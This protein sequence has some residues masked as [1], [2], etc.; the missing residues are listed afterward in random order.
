MILLQRTVFPAVNFDTT[1]DW[2][3]LLSQDLT[4]GYL[5]EPGMKRLQALLSAD[6]KSVV[7]ERHYIDKDYRNTFTHFH[8]KRFTTPPS[9]CLRLH[10]FS[11]HISEEQLKGE[12]DLL[13]ENT[14]YLGYSVIRATRPN[15]IGRT[16]ICDTV[17][18]DQSS[19]VC[20][21]AENVHLM[22]TKLK[23]SGFPFISQDADA[24]VCA[25][26]ALWMLLRYFSNRYPNYRET[27]PFQITQ[28]ASN[29]AVGRR[30]FPSGG[31]T[32]WQIAEALR[33]NQFAPLV[34]SPKLRKADETEEEYAKRR[35]QFEH[36]LYTYIESGFPLLVTVEGHVFTAYGHSSNFSTA[37]PHSAGQPFFS[38]SYNQSIIISDDNCY[39]YQTLNK[40]GPN[41][42][43]CSRFSFNEITSFIVPLPEKVFLTAESAQSAIMN[44]LDD[45]KTGIDAQSPTLAGEE[46]TYRL[47]LTTTRSF[48]SKLRDR[49]MGNKIV[50][51]YYRQLPLPHFI[52]VCEIAL[53]EEYRNEHKIQGEVIWDATR[54]A[55]E[56]QGWI[57]V[58]YP[59]I[60]SLDIGSAL[61]SK[62][63]VEAIKLQGSTSY[64][65]LTS[66]LKNQP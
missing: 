15:S 32:S 23:V 2:N 60:L 14:K 27:L 5:D 63:H 57:A 49:G 17:R 62:K 64:P 28:L 47:Y 65:L 16:L 12:S 21:C 9:R 66:N 29:H 24:T 40:A 13:G 26:S 56:P 8:A 3:S 19:H 61:N 50:S 54:N 18:F 36:L 35:M 10:F 37:I 22:G 30:V 41:S 45:P 6:C 39:P 52:W 31:L 34:Y 25:E 44:I 1:D 33:L 58:H 43:I 38:S 59:E 51:E 46:L 20:R 11:E 7:I 42:S 53:S 48:K 4:N 55:H